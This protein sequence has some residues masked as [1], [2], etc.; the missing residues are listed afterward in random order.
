MSAAAA[1]WLKSERD[2]FA[3]LKI[4]EGSGISAFLVNMLSKGPDQFNTPKLQQL[5]QRLAENPPA[6]K[7][8]PVAPQPAL[9][10][11]QPDRPGPAVYSPD[12]D[13]EKTIRIKEIIKQLFKEMTHLKAQLIHLPEGEKLYECARDLLTKSL[14][15][16]DLWDH[17]H[18]FEKNGKWFDELPENAPKPFDLEREI[19]NLMSNRSK[20]SAK[21][22]KPLPP[23]KA[24]Y[25]QKK[26]DEINTR[27]DKF[28]KL[29]DGA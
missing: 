23:A 3:G 18:Y 13:L 20:A 4:L 27:I 24:A 2:Y 29:R 17:L 6:T 1:Q 8:E 22:A 19:K 16:Q 7:P 11:P 28:K 12:K 14:R 10:A 15:R 21:L 25:Y 9:V 5:I 26:V